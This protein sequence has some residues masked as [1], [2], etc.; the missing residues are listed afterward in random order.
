MLS[1]SFKP[2]FPSIDTFALLSSALPV[3]S[4]SVIS[5]S[6]LAVY[7]VISLSNSGVNSTFLIVKEAKFLLLDLLFSSSSFG[8]SFSSLGFVSVIKL[9]AIYFVAPLYVTLYHV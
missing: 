5:P 3:I 9:L 1:P 8:S 7:C 2:V 6:I 4:K